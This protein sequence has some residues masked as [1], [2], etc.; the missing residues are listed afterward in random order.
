MVD[1]SL[2]KTALETCNPESSISI[3]ISRVKFPEVAKPLWKRGLGDEIQRMSGPPTILECDLQYSSN[4]DCDFA[5]DSQTRVII[6]ARILTLSCGDRVMQNSKPSERFI[7]FVAYLRK[8]PREAKGE[9]NILDLRRE[10]RVQRLS[11]YADWPATELDLIE[12]EAAGY[13]GD[14]SLKR[15]LDGSLKPT[16]MEADHHW[17]DSPSPYSWT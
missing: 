4:P 13:R 3:F 2:S 16:Q 14:S 1:Y 11:E 9:L 7:R 8:P 5:I 10:C 17:L 12:R 6:H 15:V